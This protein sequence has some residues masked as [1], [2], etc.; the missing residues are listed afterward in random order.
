VQKT[1]KLQHIFAVVFL[2]VC[3][4]GYLFDVLFLDKHLS[5][6]DFALEKPSWEIEF[7]KIRAQNI[8]L[9]DSPA[10]HYPYRKEFWEAA[11]QGYNAQYLPHIFTGKPTV[12]QGTGIF[13][14]S[15]FQLVM[16][17]PNAIDFSTWFR[18]LLA[19][20][21][22]YLFLTQ[23]GLSSGA[24]TLGAVAWSFNLHQIA[25]LMFPQHLAT[26]LWL[27]LLLSLNIFVLNNTKNITGIIG[28]I[29]CVVF[30]YTSGYTQI[31]LYSFIFVG[32]FNTL[33]ILIVQKDSRVQKIKNWMLI[34]C[35]YLIAGVFLLPDALWQAQEI[36]EG[37]RGAQ[38]FRHNKY[39]LDL[40]F[41]SI[42]QL[43]KDFFPRPIEVIRF[44]TANY[45]SDFRPIPS[46]KAIF[47]SNV[48]E[49]QVFFGFLCLYFCVYGV[50]KGLIKRQRLLVVW[51]LML[52]FCIALANGNAILI[53]LLNM[54]PFAGSGTYSRIMTLVLL[55]AII[56]SAYG[57]DYFIEDVHK[58]K[59]FAAIASI[60]LII[61]WL[62]SAK[63][64]FPDIVLYREFY[65]LLF[66]LLGFIGICFLLGRFQHEKL[67]YSLVIII[68]FAE[69]AHGGYGFNTR[70]NS[71]HHF[72]KNQIINSIQQT[73]GN[74]RTA[75][76]MDHPGYQHNIPSY[77]D[78]ST[79]GGY[80]TTV[81]NDYLYFMRKAYQSVH[82]TANGILFLF[83][84]N[85]EIL[86]LL[87]TH[88]VVSN[89]GLKSD[90][91]TEVYK[92]DA[93]SLYKLNDPLDRAYC[94]TDQIINPS[95]YEI[96]Y[97]LA[98]IAKTLD[99]P[100]IVEK[101]LLETET[102]TE[103]CNVS[104]LNAYSSK[105]EFDVESDQATIVFI[106]TNF[107]QYWNAEINGKSAKIHKAN[108]TFMALVIEPGKSQIKL[109][110]INQKLT[111]AA[112]LLIILGLI[113]ISIGLTRHS[114]GWRKAVFILCGVLLIGKNLMSIPG[115]MNTD[116][117]ERPVISDKK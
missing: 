64:T 5:A 56:I 60:G 37:L 40:S 59:Y 16:D 23:L 71:E 51:V 43:L 68:T 61:L 12:G 73:P 97:Q 83:D 45:H 65:L 17:I 13:S 63:D 30:F 49:Y 41:G 103:H 76:L 18:L 112:V 50:V 36:S 62:V 107:H 32:L 42:L 70:L 108:F 14:T 92:N 104:N 20:G 54:I 114:T 72:P 2:F 99:R 88:Y 33:Y 82:V 81:P 25:W 27:P 7:G 9:S 111:L 24:A 91:I 47:K 35:V 1:K 15:L 21:L 110:F 4:T 116:I 31:V 117:P 44:F 86:R 29:L 57:L 96:P 8:F 85:L 75:F 39:A 55:V 38:K 78:I 11:K 87:N 10:A 46:L 79:L 90:L 105:L 6:F 53:S 3:T 26:Q 101:A 95:V 48:V 28:L 84:G 94:V 67:I 19:A 80:E 113:S 22:M 58:R 89:L 100:M 77:Y 115:I 34:H 52:C 106:P 102:L 74:F 98:G 109:E 93:E 66:L 69:L